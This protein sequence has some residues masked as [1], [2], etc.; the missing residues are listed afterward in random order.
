VAIVRYSKRAKQDLLDIWLWIARD[1]GTAFADDIVERIERRGAGLAEFPEMGVA[2]PE[3]APD[4]RS[5]VAERW[6]LL[7]RVED[8]DV[9]VVRVVDGARDLTRVW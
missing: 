1:K 3:I 4:A 6:L 7:Y 5:L 2:R 8:A 9:L